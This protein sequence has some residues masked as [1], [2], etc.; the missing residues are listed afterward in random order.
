VVEPGDNLAYITLQFYGSTNEFTC[1]YEANRRQI[2]QPNDIRVAQ[3][4]LIP[5]A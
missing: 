4:L 3:R 5:N 1:I 2:A